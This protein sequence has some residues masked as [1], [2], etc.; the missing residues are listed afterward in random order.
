MNKKIVL[1][2]VWTIGWIHVFFFSPSLAESGSL[3][4][5][6]DAAMN[7]KTDSIDALNYMFFNLLGVWPFVMIAMLVQDLQGKIKAWPFAFSTMVFGNSAL[8]IYLFCR[9][10]QG[11]YVAPKTLLVRFAESKILAVLLLAATVYLYYYGYTAAD[12]QVFQQTWQS[13]FYAAAIV[14]DFF[15]FSIAFA[16][17]LAD[18][19]RRRN[20]PVNGLFWFFVLLPLLGAT[21]YLL[22]RK[23]LPDSNIG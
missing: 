2:I 6:L 5:Y 8:Y 3:M 4:A 19:M 11:S 17:V 1:A 16:F 15:L 22:I 23:K 10:E 7:N 20:M 12:F 21:S 9:K 18:D 14:A 13:N